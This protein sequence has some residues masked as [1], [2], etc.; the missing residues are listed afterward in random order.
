MRI[1]VCVRETLY[2]G[3]P[4]EVNTETGVAEQKEP[5]PVYWLPTHDRCALE[6]AVRIREALGNSE[7]IAFTVAP[8]RASDSLYRCLAMGADRVVHVVDEE[9]DTSTSRVVAMILGEVLKK[10]CCDLVLCGD[11]SFD[12]GACQVPQHLA[13]LL[14]VPQVTRVLDVQMLPG[15]KRLKVVRKLERGNRETVECSL[16]AVVA[17]DSALNEPR[18]VSLHA[19][20]RAVR[21][22]GSD[23]EVDADTARSVG[24][25][26][27]NLRV[28]RF[29]PPRPPV[30]KMVM[31]DMKASAAD[32]LKFILSG[33]SA[34]KMSDLLDGTTDEVVRQLIG[35]LQR[36]GFILTQ[37]S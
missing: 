14:D 37:K 35:I 23:Y 22:R 31:P 5:C 25:E 32:R 9:P 20:Y 11:C 7:V 24:S 4:Y 8:T 6:E 28:A 17:V 36:E 33:S 26:H 21:A 19:C 18:Y 27:R 2:P 30:K 1:A 12:A 34:E 15:Q 10:V 16:P 3:V 29:I 13:A